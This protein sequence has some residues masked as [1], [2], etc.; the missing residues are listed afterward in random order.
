MTTD[1]NEKNRDRI[2]I[3]DLEVFA[4]HGV[5]PEENGENR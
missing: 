4:N 3:V 1:R 2:R 5:F